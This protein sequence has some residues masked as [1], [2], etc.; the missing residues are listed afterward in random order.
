MIKYAYLSLFFCLC[1]FSILTAQMYSDSISVNFFLIDECRI[2][3]NISGE[4]NHVYETFAGEPFTFQAYFPNTSS[5]EKKIAGFVADYKIAFPTTTDHNKEKAIHYGASIA[6]EVVVYDEINKQVLY[7]GRID[8][9]YA[10]IGSRRRVITSRDLRTALQHIIDQK[11]ITN[12]ETQAIGCFL[13]AQK[14]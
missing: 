12:P 13:N 7:R 6:P 1:S 10:S 11:E 2:S 14:Q 5:T 8:N 4:I 9:S 3:Q